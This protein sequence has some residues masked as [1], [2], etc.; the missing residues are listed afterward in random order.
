MGGEATGEELRG[1][2]FRDFCSRKVR[3]GQRC[4]GSK[5]EG[6]RERTLRFWGEK[7]QVLERRGGG[8]A[9]VEVLSSVL[10]TLDDELMPF[11]CTLT[12]DLSVSHRP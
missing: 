8:A 10:H 3:V 7:D 6:K 9:L 12:S 5:R 4:L 11:L 2:V 1:E